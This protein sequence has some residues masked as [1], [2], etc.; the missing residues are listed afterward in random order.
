MGSSRGKKK[1]GSAST[2]MA[3]SHLALQGP[4]K[5]KAQGSLMDV[6]DDE[7][8]MQMSSFSDQITAI[9]LKNNNYKLT[10]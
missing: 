3:N 10:G 2:I 4:K 9:K 7:R 1:K 5:R 6:V 8:F